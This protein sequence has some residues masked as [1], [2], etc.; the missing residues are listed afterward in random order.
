VIE[1]VNLGKSFKIH[2][3]EP[4]F[5]GSVRSLFHRKWEIKHAL[6]EVSF[7]IKEGELVGLVGAN[8]AGKTTIVKLLAGIIYPSTGTATVL[9]F[10]P[11]ERK[12]EFRK[13]IGLLM[14]QKAQLWWDLT[15]ADCFLLL[16]DIYQVDKSVH[17][18]S[19]TELVETLGVSSLLDIQI[20]RL[21][22]GERMKMELIASLLHR[23]KVLFLDEPTLGLDLTA[24]RAIRKFLLEYVSKHKPAVLLTSHYMQ[25]IEELCDRIMIIREG[26]FVYDG[27]LSQVLSTYAPEKIIS[28]TCKEPKALQ[29]IL[30]ATQYRQDPTETGAKVHVPRAQVNSFLSSVLP[31]IEVD[32]I[33]IEE[34]EIGSI[35]ESIMTKDRNAA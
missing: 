26:S 4:G 29:Q 34:E 1:A 25:D 5:W 17:K 35:I 11:W 2:K 24:Q 31:K 13:Q 10:T 28:F 8:G 23:P 15:G 14:G 18:E 22:L 9:G 3:K 27:P 20:R 6:K 12:N 7:S 21:S 19:L 33:L 16:R 30:G 32:D